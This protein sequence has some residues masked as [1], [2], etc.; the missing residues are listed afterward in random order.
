[1]IRLGPKF[2]GHTLNVIHTNY[3]D[4]CWEKA[5][6]LWKPIATIKKAE[7]KAK[8]F[9]LKNK[10][11]IVKNTTEPTHFPLATALNSN[12]NPP[13]RRHWKNESL[14]FRPKSLFVH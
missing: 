1:M 4:G 14:V 11:A 10:G 12:P 6:H 13:E 9:R 2:I 8:A 7:G 5:I 3:A